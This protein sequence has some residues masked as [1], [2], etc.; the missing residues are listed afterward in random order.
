MNDRLK[1]AIGHGTAIKQEREEAAAKRKQEQEEVA[2][3]AVDRNTAYWKREL[4]Q[5]DYLYSK[6]R[7][8]VAAGETSFVIRGGKEL[9]N[10]INA[11]YPGVHARYDSGEINVNSEVQSQGPVIESVTVTWDTPPA[12]EKPR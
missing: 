4:A 2:R 1:Q 12:E 11:A 5:N 10:V 8:A 6:I 3:A 7:D 9:V